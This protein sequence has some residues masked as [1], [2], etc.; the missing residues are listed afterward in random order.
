MKD[1][2]EAA[3]EEEAVASRLIVALDVPTIDDARAMIDALDG[4]VSFFKIGLWLAFARG[5]DRLLEDLAARRKRVFLD[6]KM[7]DIPATVA[8]GA[9]AAADRGVALL[10][11]HAEPATVAAAVRGRGESGLR[12]L[13]VTVLTSLT[14]ADLTAGGSRLGARE[15]VTLRARQ[16]VA[17]GADGIV[18]SAADDPNALRTALRAPDLLIVT[19]G[20]RPATSVPDDQR[21]TA[22][23]AAA[24]LRG[25]DYLVVGRPIVR[26]A[27]PRRAAVDIIAEMKE[28]ARQRRGSSR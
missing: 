3:R 12:I 5:L 4:V 28:G 2:K 6:T 27:D 24:I 9:A 16:A 14:D 11:V 26:S 13:A 20:I 10:T 17:A 8:A 1:S 15:L 25:A 22:T 23:P 7:L 21:R 18:A 19:P